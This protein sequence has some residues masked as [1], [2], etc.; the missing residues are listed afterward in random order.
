[1]AGEKDMRVGGKAIL[2]F[3]VVLM[4]LLSPPWTALAQFRGGVQG[5]VR[6]T[7]G[8]VIPG[9]AV[10][11]TDTATNESRTT[12]TNGV[13]FYSFTVLAA[14]AY[15]VVA[16]KSGFKAMTLHQVTV[17]A[18]A[19]QGL[20]ITL[21]PGAVSQSVTV[22]A[23]TNPAFQTQGANVAGQI[24]SQ[25]IQALP[26]IGGDP[27]ELLRLAPGVFGDGQRNGAGNSVNLPNTTGPGGSNLGIFQVENQVPISANG[28]RLS[29][30][31]YEV[32]GVS[33][34]SLTWGGASVL[35]PNQGSIQ[36]MDVSSVSYDA[37]NGR[38]SGAS[39]DVV[40]KSGT[41][42]FHGGGSFL[43]QSPGLNAYNSWGGPYGAPDERV[44]NRFS[45][46]GGDIG[47]PIKKNKLFFMFSYLGLRENTDNFQQAFLLTPQFM[48][49]VVAARPGSFAAK[50][51]S[52]PGMAPRVNKVLAVPCSAA[53]FQT[54]MA[55]QEVPG[56]LNIGSLTGAAGDYV[57]NP[58]GGGLSTTPD[59]EFAQFL[60]PLTNSGNQYNGRLDYDLDSKDLLF[61]TS[62]VTTVRTFG[63]DPTT[64]S[65]PAADVTNSPLNQAETLAWNRTLS[66]TW[67]NEARINFTRY[68]YNQLQGSAGTNFGIPRTEVQGF[69]FGRLEFGPPWSTTTPGIFAEN[70]LDF[71]DW[72]TKAVGNHELKFGTE[73]IRE[74]DNNKLIGGTRP[75]YVFN[76]V[77][78]LA[79]SAPIFEQIDANP[80]TGGPANAP[81]YLRTGDYALF[82]QDRWQMRPNL[83]L[84]AGLRWEYYSP[85]SVAN[86]TIGNLVFG[87]QQLSN[88]RVVPEHQLYNPDYRN[89]A[90]RFAFAYSPG[91]IRHLVV[92]G[93]FGMYFDRFPD[94]LFTNAQENP[95][96][97]ASYAICCGTS[98]SPF[99][100]GAIQL[101][102]GG[103][104]SPSSFPVNP[105]LAIGIDPATGA[106]TSPAVSVTVY[107]AQPSM[108]TPYAYVYNLDTQ[109]E[110]PDHWVL[111]VGYAGSAAHHMARFVPQQFL[112]KPNPAFFAVYFPQPDTNSNYNALLAQITRQFS[113]GFSFQFHYTY[114]KS[115]DE[116]SYEGPGAVTNQTYPMNL[117]SEYGPSDY[118]AT[119]YIVVNGT[120]DL[121][122]YR[123]QAGFLGEILGGWQ[124]DG[125]ETWHTGFPWTVKDGQSV[126][127]PG[128]P[129]LSPIRPTGYC[130]CA[131]N[132]TSNFAYMNPDF[133]FFGGPSKY[134]TLGTGFPGVGR[135]SFRG[136]GFMETDASLVKRIKLPWLGEAGDMELRAN[137]Y[138]LF[139]QL[140]LLPL[141]FFSAG[142][143]A[144]NSRFFGLADGGGA[145]RVIELQARIAF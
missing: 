134:F 41:N 106:P 87:S 100:A 9:A 26:Q 72:S 111:D 66:P 70:T 138:N 52:E 145:G 29:E 56:G 61:F 126:I 123:S 115:L 81:P 43:R 98:S 13:G 102:F 3:L 1:M 28:Q 92:R 6:D 57:D 17:G 112:Y 103:S 23:E 67:I 11:I 90:P 142:T 117:A 30:N 34:N 71:S 124:I 125:I 84:T 39:I 64:G 22:T 40:S 113:H 77:W 19:T 14:G 101:G 83:T 129:T 99:D 86:G 51:F 5:T 139:N 68:A 122:F 27:F 10:T 85:L 107:G 141:G 132:P 105:N 144:D 76:S 96:G 116:L 48:Q 18:Q 120:Y 16:R 24:T 109:Y 12:T 133:A 137:F 63:A 143:F 44:A 131:P 31:N 35:T 93:G 54:S 62:Y 104:H 75:D 95:P 91:K 130:N 114:S 59:L 45:Q 37:Q 58:I 121:P 8:A 80:L 127:T 65:A 20:N 60:V 46:F 128:G 25:Q 94:V 33:V 110:F 50:L 53:G 73:I 97:F 136:P 4:A 55:C 135:N 2:A 21:S 42:R 74:Q 38:N 119:H 140:N 108:G 118:D 47:G 32:D 89:F 15:T 69:Q 82:A 88:S 36:E 7:S 78:D 49:S 79:N